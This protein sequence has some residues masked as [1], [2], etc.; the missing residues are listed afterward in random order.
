MVLSTK[1]FHW[2]IPTQDILN[3]FHGRIPTQD[4]FQLKCYLRYF[5]ACPIANGSPRL[6]NL[7]TFPQNNNL[8][9]FFYIY[10]P[11]GPAARESV[12]GRLL[13]HL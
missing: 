3:A 2:R 13:Y 11:I 8:N 6:H 10:K 12:Q 1:I 7:L 4:S 5:R 9:R